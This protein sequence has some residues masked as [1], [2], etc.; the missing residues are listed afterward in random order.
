MVRMLG[1]AGLV[2]FGATLH[3]VAVADEPKG[4]KA[5][6]A[7]PTAELLAKLRQPITLPAAEMTL[8]EFAAA[9]EKATGV[10]V[11]IN[12]GAFRADGAGEEPDAMPPVRPAR[13]KGATAAA[14]LRQT[15]GKRE[16]T[17]LIR[18][19]HVE[20]VPV[21]YALKES[22]E[23]NRT[24]KNGEPITPHPLVSAVFRERPLNA[25]L[26]ELAAEYDL[27]VV[28]APQAADQKAAFVT[29][30]L[31]NVPADRA[32]ELLALQADLRVI[33]RGAAFVVTSK[34]HAEGL[35]NERMDREQRKIELENLRNPLGG[36]LGQPGRGNGAALCGALGFAGNLGNL[37]GGPGGGAGFGGGQMGQPAPR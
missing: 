34:E 11:V 33:R 15:L 25:A 32:V 7:D 17:Y 16:A 21:A 10:G 4:G 8:P 13:F 3:R 19:D 18:R 28:V 37:G 35:F 31:L 29:A 23:A 36:M 12:E 24:D 20:I 22:R 14:V 26:E 2:L 5:A 30:R 1:L 9:V 27:T 6:P